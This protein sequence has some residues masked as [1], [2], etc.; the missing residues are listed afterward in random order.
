[1]EQNHAEINFGQARGVLSPIR[2][3]IFWLR[4][5]EDFSAA[6]T[7]EVLNFR[8]AGVERHL[9]RARRELQ[10]ALRRDGLAARR[11]RTLR[12]A[13]RRGDNRGAEHDE[14]DLHTFDLRF[15]GPGRRAQA[16]TGA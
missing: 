11:A 2:T 14:R 6:E 9:E 3:A 16:R 13:P 5:V 8:P 12:R 15:P 10:G 1:M 4:E 7:A